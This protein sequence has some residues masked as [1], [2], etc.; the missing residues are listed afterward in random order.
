MTQHPSAD[1]AVAVVTG[2]GTGIGAAIG[3]RLAADGYA[4]VLGYRSS[5]D[6]VSA[7]EQAIAEQGGQALTHQVDV[8][9]AE[10]CRGLVEATIE[11][12]GRCDLLVNNAAVIDFR[13]VWEIDEDSLMQT[14]A[15][16]VGGPLTL[17][18]LAARRMREQGG[19]AIVNIGSVAGRGAL[20]QRV[21]YTASK[22]SVEAL[23]RSLALELGPYN[24][25]VNC[26]APGSITVERHRALG[27]GYGSLWQRHVPLGREGRPEEVAEVVT[28]IGGPQ[29]SYVT[30]QVIGV[31]GGL[32]AVARQPD[33]GE[34]LTGTVQS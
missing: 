28:F 6:G 24:I 12:F 20:H 3:R 9:S 18:L 31:D 32:L 10:Q 16:N 8:A 23:T 30:G 5:K 17:S 26:V 7:V 27:E 15:V 34:F 19:G 11:R 1:R 22:G 33:A 4:V 13:P 14:M 2:A 21:S 29:A 25:R